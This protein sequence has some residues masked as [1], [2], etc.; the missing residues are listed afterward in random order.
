MSLVPSQAGLCPFPSHTPGD[1]GFQG[2]QKSAIP[3]VQLFPCFWTY[4][5]PIRYRGLSLG[6][7]EVLSATIFQNWSLL[8]PPLS[9]P[10]AKPGTSLLV[11]S[12][13][14]G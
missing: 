1:E 10:M 14:T 13:G 11:I 6:S 3:Q 5:T 2:R 8:S 7:L 9:P 4:P 12:G